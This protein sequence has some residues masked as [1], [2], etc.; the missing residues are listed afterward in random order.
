MTLLPEYTQ[1]G[2]FLMSTSQSMYPFG[3][4]FTATT[5]FIS[6]IQNESRR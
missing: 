1:T 5:D 2:S 6:S 3:F 4:D